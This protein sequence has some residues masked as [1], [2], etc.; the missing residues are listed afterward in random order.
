MS[1][2]RQIKPPQ[3]LNEYE[4]EE[5]KKTTNDFK[6]SKSVQ[7]SKVNQKSKSNQK[8]SEAKRQIKLPKY[9]DEYEICGL[10]LTPHFTLFDPAKHDTDTW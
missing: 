9:L 10:K 7:K 4:L 3:Y 6:K 5:N 1:Q 2:K 8:S